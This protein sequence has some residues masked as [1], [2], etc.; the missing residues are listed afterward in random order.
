M[1]VPSRA[2]L[3]RGALLTPPCEKSKLALS[4]DPVSGDL[5]ERTTVEFYISPG[6][7]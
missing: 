3:P 7:S 1:P 2:E 5:V 4:R 6:T